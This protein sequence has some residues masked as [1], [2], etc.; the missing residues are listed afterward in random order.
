VDSEY[1]ERGAQ[2]AQYKS[3]TILRIVDPGK[4]HVDHAEDRSERSLTLPQ[5]LNTQ[6]SI[7]DRIAEVG[8]FASSGRI[9]CENTSLVSQAG[10]FDVSLPNAP[11]RAA[12]AKPHVR[13]SASQLFAS[14]A[15]LSIKR[16]GSEAIPIRFRLSRL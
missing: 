3:S 14:R 1:A 15:A 12:A 9:R 2:L 4:P 5:E 6:T 10:F 11:S 7:R 16:L 8:M 13:K